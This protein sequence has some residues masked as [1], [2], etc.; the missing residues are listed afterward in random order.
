MKNSH[1]L[2]LSKPVVAICLSIAFCLAAGT[3]VLSVFSIRAVASVSHELARAQARLRTDDLTRIRDMITQRLS[4]PENFPGS[5]RAAL[6]ELR[7]F[8]DASGARET[9]SLALR[10]SAIGLRSARLQIASFT[11]LGLAT[12][13]AGVGFVLYIRRVNELE[14]MI[15]VCAWTKRVKYN[16]RWISFE[17]Y[18]HNRFHIEFT[19]SISE[20][21]AKKLMQEELQ[22]HPGLRGGPPPKT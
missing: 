6:E 22:L 16:G 14:T 19:H 15:T 1:P 9:D 13:M 4:S 7:R 12:L 10:N 5:D 8:L 18:L 11:M 2:L 3:A 20:D 17:D 21:A